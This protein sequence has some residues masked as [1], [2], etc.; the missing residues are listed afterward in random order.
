M[1]SKDHPPLHTPDD[2]GFTAAVS[3]DPDF[4]IQIRAQIERA[5]AHAQT[6]DEHW[7]TLRTILYATPEERLRFAQMRGWTASLSDE[8]GA[9]LLA[10]ASK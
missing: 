4:D 8:E 7:P 6:S 3:D 9:R 5:L 10:G 2:S 1:N